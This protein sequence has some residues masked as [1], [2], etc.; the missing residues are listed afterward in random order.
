MNFSWEQI[1][2]RLSQNFIPCLKDHLLG[3]LLGHDFDGDERSFTAE[4]R[5]NLIFANNR[6]YKHKV[7]RVNYTTYD[8]H[9]AQ[10]SLN[11]HT[12]A[13]F[14]TLSHEDDLPDHKRFPY[15]FGRIIGLFHTVVQ[16]HGPGSQTMEPQ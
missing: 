3:R 2:D 16:Y 13:D 10:D 8:L 14:M 4:E 9:R 6:I 5:N 7:L 12:H 11:S 1:S 15:W